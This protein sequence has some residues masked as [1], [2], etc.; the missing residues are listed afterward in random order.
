MR[1]DREGRDPMNDDT[2]SRQS[3]FVNEAIKAVQTQ[4]FYMKRAMYDE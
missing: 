1:K 2:A 3:G 4:A